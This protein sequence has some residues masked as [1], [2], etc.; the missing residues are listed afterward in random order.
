MAGGRGGRRVRRP[1]FHLLDGEGAVDAGTV[2]LLALRVRGRGGAEGRGVRREGERSESAH[3]IHLPQ[4]PSPGARCPEGT[5]HERVTK[6]RA[7]RLGSTININ[8]RR[9]S[10]YL[11]VQAAHGGA[12]ALGAHADDVDVGADLKEGGGREGAGIRG[13]QGR[14]RGR[15]TE[16]SMPHSRVR[17]YLAVA[18]RLHPLQPRP[19]PPPSL[20]RPTLSP[21][22]LM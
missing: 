16:G 18:L 6:S 15:G 4:P 11:L 17:C 10:R 3:P 22:E 12:H 14:G 20:K 2:H 5:V 19:P 8:E 13:K 9:A 21:T 7:A 1:P